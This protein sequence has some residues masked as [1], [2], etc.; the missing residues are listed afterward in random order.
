MS[1]HRP[2]ALPQVWQV[3]LTHHAVE[4]FRERFAEVPL[5][6][7]AAT[8]LTPLVHSAVAAGAQRIIRSDGMIVCAVNGQITTVYWLEPGAKRRRPRRMHQEDPA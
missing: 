7:V 2:I 8:I 4:R 1:L 3:G 6:A 5:D